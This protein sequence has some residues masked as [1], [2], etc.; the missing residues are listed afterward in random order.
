MRTG[1]S[2]ITPRARRNRRKWRRCLSSTEPRGSSADGDA[3]AAEA[4]PVGA[5]SEATRRAALPPTLAKLV[6]VSSPPIRFPM[7]SLRCDVEV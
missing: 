5:A 4:G 3:E 2:R 6:I 7:A 1:P